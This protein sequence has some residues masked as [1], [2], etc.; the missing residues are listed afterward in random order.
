MAMSRFLNRITIISV[1]GLAFVWGCGPQEPKKPAVEP[2]KAAPKAEKA[3]KFTIALKPAPDQQTGYRITTGLRKTIKWEGPVPPGKKGEFDESYNDEQV[4]MTV[5]QR[6]QG[7]D[8]SGKVTAQVTIDSLKYLSITKNLT[9]VDFDSTRQSD[10]DS[11]LAKLLGQSYT[12][13]FEPNNYVTSVNAPQFE[14]PQQDI[15]GRTTITRTGQNILSPETIKERHGTL[16]LPP[17][18]QEKIKPGDKWSR[19]K[20]FHF[21]MMGL[22]SYEKIFTLKEVRNADGHQIA[23]IAMNAIPSSEVESKFR[24]QQAIGNFPRMFDTEDVYTGQGE[25][26]LTAG[27]ID[28]YTEKLQANWIAA[29]PQ[30]PAQAADANEPVVLRMSAIRD[31]KIERIK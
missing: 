12:M 5:T 7:L 26:D 25:I 10:K 27:R 15:I 28:N 14:P 1:V 8:S 19:I 23:V 4:E 18:G 16:I 6:I 13:E 29:L 9:S 2:G 30:N 31:Y 24:D 20:T 11:P 21:G 3:G 17:Q 22:K